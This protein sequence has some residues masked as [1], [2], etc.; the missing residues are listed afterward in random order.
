MGLA[1]KIRF[2][3]NVKRKLKKLFLKRLFCAIYEWVGFA[4]KLV[5]ESRN[6]KNHDCPFRFLQSVDGRY[7]SSSGISCIALASLLSFADLVSFNDTL[8]ACGAP[9]S[10]RQSVAGFWHY[11]SLA[12]WV[13]TMQGPGTS[14]SSRHIPSRLFSIFLLID[15]SM[16]V[17]TSE[18]LLIDGASLSLTVC[19]FCFSFG[20]HCFQSTE[21]FPLLWADLSKVSITI[22]DCHSLTPLDPSA[23]ICHLGRSTLDL[24]ISLDFSTR[25]H[26]SFFKCQY[27]EFQIS[28]SAFLISHWRTWL[29]LPVDSIGL[30]QAKREVVTFRKKTLAKFYVLYVMSIRWIQKIRFSYEMQ[31]PPKHL[32]ILHW[33]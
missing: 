22:W 16:I 10:G 19:F 3:G 30:V 27:F 11:L 17:W 32:V 18:S 33:G 9:P 12:Q 8:G 23:K 14:Y 5:S 21:T 24:T 31:L 26:C 29:P 20:R 13:Y 6:L 15:W 4:V 2:T 7:T 28:F 25:I 1:F